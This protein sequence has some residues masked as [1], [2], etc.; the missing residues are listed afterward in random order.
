ME[1]QGVGSSGRLSSG[2][3][4]VASA[5][6]GLASASGTATFSVPW[7]STDALSPT[8]STCGLHLRCGCGCAHQ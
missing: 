1:L 6:T 5:G 2:Y 4:C 7:S 3:A 8:T